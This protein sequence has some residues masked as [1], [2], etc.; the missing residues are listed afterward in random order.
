[1]VPE[2]AKARLEF[3]E[4]V[5][6]IR[7]ELHRYC[8]RLTGSIIDGEDIVQDTLA[9]AFYALSMATDLP[10]LRPW[11]FRV[12]HNAAID[13]LRRTRREPF[14]DVADADLPDDSPDP[15]VARLALRAFLVLPVRQR[16]AVILKDVL[17]LSLEEIAAA[18][19][20]TVM[21]VKAALVRGRA[22]LRATAH[23]DD[24]PAPSSESRDL[25]SRYVALFNA[26]DWTGLQSLL[27]SDARLDLV[28]QAQRQGRAVGEYY[29]RYAKLPDIRA[30]LG[31]VD[32]QEAILVF[33]PSAATTPTYFILL[34]WR[35]GHVA[36][37][38]DYRYVP[39]L[40]AELG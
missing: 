2:L 33:E 22:T 17:G 1:M 19:D 29:G 5:A 30:S 13:H 10:P 20:T 18:M 11:L 38:R 28:G 35:D 9:K 39:Y 37:I 24:A 12:A 34:E 23:S 27:A 6:T 31:V 14:D 4:L 3:H 26:R 40:A 7:P 8:A 16:S 15:E 25:L 21:A 36:A 32:G